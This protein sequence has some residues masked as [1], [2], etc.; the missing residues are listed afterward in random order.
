MSTKLF[1]GQHDDETVVHVFR[2]HPVVMRRGLIYFLLAVLL[3]MIPS[4]IEPEYSYLFWGLAGGLL[5]GSIFMFFSWVGWYFTLNIVT[6]QRFIQISQDG[7][8]KRSVVD[9]GLD[10]IQNINYQISGLQ[11]TVLGF[12]TIVVQTFVGDLVLKYIHHPARVQESLIKTIKENG[13]D[14][15]G[16]E[17]ADVKSVEE[18]EAE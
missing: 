10:K 6:D 15:S 3:G 17:I 14:Y 4:L 13:Y 18:I 8:F 11:E 1:D 12:G 16:Q 5:L 7:L 2:R 9:I